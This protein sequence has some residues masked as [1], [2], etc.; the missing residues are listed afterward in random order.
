MHT[1]DPDYHADATPR[2]CIRCGQ[3]IE[4][5]CVHLCSDQWAVGSL[6]LRYEDTSSDSDKL[7]LV[8]SSY[9]T[10][11]P[12]ASCGQP[13][14]PSLAGMHQCPNR[15]P[16]AAA[17]MIVASTPTTCARCNQPI[18]PSPTSVHVCPRQS[19]FEAPEITNDMLYRISSVADPTLGHSST[20]C[21][22]CGQAINP[23]FT[24]V[25]VCPKQWSLETPEITHGVLV[26]DLNR[27]SAVTGTSIYSTQAPCS[28]YGQPVEPSRIS[29]YF[30]P[31]RST[32]DSLRT[33]YDLP[34]SNL[35]SNWAATAG[36]PCT[37]PAPCALCGQLINPSMAGLHVCCW[38]SALESPGITQGVPGS[39]LNEISGVCRTTIGPMSSPCG[40]CGQV[41]NGSMS[42]LHI[43]AGRS[44]FDLGLLA[45]GPVGLLLDR[46]PA[47]GTDFFSGHVVVQRSGTE[48]LPRIEEDGPPQSG[49][50]LFEARIVVGLSVGTASKWT[51]GDAMAV[52]IRARQQQR[53]LGRVTIRRQSGAW[54]SDSGSPVV[55]EDSV[56]IEIW[57]D[58][59]LG[60]EQFR[61]EMTD[62][63]RALCRDLQQ[64]VVV[65][66]ILDRNLMRERIF[67]NQ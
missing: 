37:S 46:N 56:E 12:C 32:L 43:C 48:S 41:I 38:Q 6:G 5:I 51:D 35:S 67:V 34:V 39:D 3:P 27:T 26:S 15:W 44:T 36:K 29:A 17:S 58:D 63:A 40:H 64:E 49:E 33:T 52:T 16:L 47:T 8:S 66:K 4:V 55:L 30:C 21:A 7:S 24:S 54:Q 25:H 14:S 20:P 19:M 11:A 53:R 31:I 2:T 50:P 28:T 65:L 10:P 59:N 61:S 22:H 18:N 1:D 45:P 62:L 60:Y 57:D 42:S 9:W 23:S 13:I